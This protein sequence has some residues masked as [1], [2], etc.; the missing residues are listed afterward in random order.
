MCMCMY[1]HMYMLHEFSIA[2]P[3]AGTRV[4]RVLQ[5]GQ[6][7]HNGRNGRATR[8]TWYQRHYRT[9]N[10]TKQEAPPDDKRPTISQRERVL[11]LRFTDHHAWPRQRR[12]QDR[13]RARACVFCCVQRARSI[14]CVRKAG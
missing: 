3:R 12:A 9:E 8:L 1:M 4:S 10:C 5:K 2:S 7:F 11:C 6:L 14:S 13:A